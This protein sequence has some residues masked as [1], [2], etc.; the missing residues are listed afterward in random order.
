[1]WIFF[2]VYSVKMFEVVVLRLCGV[3]VYYFMLLRGL[4]KFVLINMIW[5]VGNWSLDMDDFFVFVDSK[6]FIFFGF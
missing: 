2:L 1:M 5:G 4:L 3:L 6:V